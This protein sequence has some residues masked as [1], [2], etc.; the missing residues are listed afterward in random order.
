VDDNDGDGDDVCEDDQVSEMPKHEAVNGDRKSAPKKKSLRPKSSKINPIQVAVDVVPSLEGLSN[1]HNE[2]GSSGGGSR[3]NSSQA[4]NKTCCHYKETDEY[5]Q[6]L[7]KY[8]GCNSIYGLS[9]DEI[10]RRTFSKF[11]QQQQRQRQ[12]HTAMEQKEFL[13]QTNEEAFAKWQVSL[14]S[15]LFQ[16][17]DILMTFTRL[18]ISSSFFS[19]CFLAQTHTHTQ[20]AV[21]KDVQYCEQVQSNQYV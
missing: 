21:Q 11:K 2:G 6:T 17:I 12:Q 5:K 19:H 10:E 20:K 7:P 4:R 14:L 9:K 1:N 8:R 13:A 3:S 16:L 18:I 15:H